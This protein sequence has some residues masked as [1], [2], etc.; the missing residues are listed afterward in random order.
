[1]AVSGDGNTIATC[2]SEGIKVRMNSVDAAMTCAHCAT[3]DTCLLHMQTWSGR[4]HL[5]LATCRPTGYCL[6]IAFAPGGR[7]IVA[8]TKEGMVQVS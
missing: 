8:G 6:T 3:I 2:S 7:Y 5:C 4:T 1:V